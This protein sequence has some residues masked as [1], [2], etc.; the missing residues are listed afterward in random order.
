MFDRTN[1]S[2]SLN[3]FDDDEKDAVLESKQEAVKK[4][5]NLDTVTKLGTGSGGKT[6]VYKTGDYAVKLF[7]GIT[8]NCGNKNL[9][10]EMSALSRIASTRFDVGMNFFHEIGT[11]A[12]LRSVNS[13]QGTDSDSHP[14]NL[15]FFTAKSDILPWKCSRFNRVGVDYA[16]QMPLVKCLANELKTYHLQKQGSP[17]EQPEDLEKIL[18]I[19]ID[20]CDALIVMHKN[21]IIHQDIKPQNIFLD[22]DNYC[23]GDLGIAR[24]EDNRQYFL[25]GTPAYWSPEQGNGQVV[26]RRCDIYS[27]GLVLYELADTVPISAHYEERMHTDKKLPKLK[28]DVPEGLK[29]ILQNAC[30]YEPSLRYQSAEAFKNDLC[31]LKKNTGYKPKSTR[32]IYKPGNSL[33]PSFNSNMSPSRNQ[34]PRS[35]RGGAGDFHMRQRANRFFQPENLWRAGKLW[36]EESRKT[37]SRFAELKID[38]KIMPLSSHSSHAADFPIRVSESTEGATKQKPLSDILKDTENLHNMYL[39]GE[40]GIGKTTALNSIMELKYKNKEFYVSKNGKTVIPLFIEL[41]KAP[42]DYCNAYYASHSTFI[43]RYLYM[44]LASVQKQHLLSESPKEMAQIMDKQ[45]TSITDNIDMLLNMDEDH[46]QYLLLLDGLNEVSKKQ[47]STKEKDFLGTPSE[48][49][50]EEIKELLEKHKNITAIITSRADETLSDLDDSFERLYLTGVSEDVIKEYLDSCKISSE[51]VSKNSRLMET[52]RIPLFLKLYGELYNTADISTPGE[53]LYAFFSERSTKYTAR[54]RIAEIK[55]D[56]QKAGDA[57]GSNSLDEKMQWFILD[58]LLPELG[59]YMEKNDLYTVDL[60]TFHQVIDTV[61]KGENETDICGTYGRKYFKEYLKGEDPI[62]N[63][64]TYAKQLL[65]LGD[66]LDEDYASVIAKYCVYSLGILYSNNQ[67]YSFI[68]QHIRDFFAAM[69][70]ITDM[71]MALCIA[72]DGRIT[73]TFDEND[74]KKKIALRVLDTIGTNY[75]DEKVSLFIGEILGECKNT[76]LFTDGKWKIYI[77]EE[78]KRLL[79]TKTLLLYKGNFSRKASIGISVHNLLGIFEKAHGNLNGMDLSELDLSR[80]SF[81]GIPLKG[82]SLN[83]ALVNKQ[84]FFPNGHDS[85]ITCIR[86]SP[87]GEFFLTGDSCGIVKLWHL[88]TRKYVQTIIDCKYSINNI[89]YIHNGSELLVSTINGAW[90]YDALHYEIKRNFPKTQFVLSDKNAEKLIVGYN[91]ILGH[92]MNIQILEQASNKRVKLDQVREDFYAN[93]VAFSPDEKYIVLINTQKQL[94]VFEYDSGKIIAKFE[95]IDICLYDW[96]DNS[97]F[98]IS[99]ETTKDLTVIRDNIYVS[100]CFDSTGKYLAIANDCDIKIFHFPK[101]LIQYEELIEYPILGS[102]KKARDIGRILY[103]CLVWEKSILDNGPVLS[104]KFV[105]NDSFLAVAYSNQSLRLYD[106]KEMLFPKKEGGEIN[107][108]LSNVLCMDKLHKNDKYLIILCD[109]KSNIMVL[110]FDNF[111]SIDTISAFLINNSHSIFVDVIE[112]TPSGLFISAKQEGRLYYDAKLNKISS[113]YPQSS[114]ELFNYEVFSHTKKVCALGK[115]NGLIVI[116]SPFLSLNKTIKLSGK[117]ILYMEFSPDDKLLLISLTDNSPEIINMETY[118]VT[119]LNTF[120]GKAD[121]AIFSEDGR[122]IFCCNGNFIEKF[123]T[124]T[125]ERINYVKEYCE[126][127]LENF[128]NRA[129]NTFKK[130]VNQYNPSN[131]IIASPEHTYHQYNSKVTAISCSPDRLYLAVAWSRGEVEIREMETL[132]CIAILEANNRNVKTISFNA[133][134]KYMAI[135]FEKSSVK[136]Y[137]T[138]TWRCISILH[139]FPTGEIKNPARQGHS[140]LVTSILFDKNIINIREPEKIITASNDGTIKYWNPFSP[141]RVTPISPSI[142]YTEKIKKS[143]ATLWRKFYLLT[144]VILGD[145]GTTVSC[146]D[147]CECEKTL[148]FVPGLDIDGTSLQNLNPASDLTKEDLEIL[149]LYGAKTE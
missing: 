46:T 79:L 114:K 39:I 48:L 60:P 121:K 72:E 33:P 116:Y 148:Y 128:A 15:I 103:D 10:D 95:L 89:Q 134:G 29:M 74:N 52:L 47:L 104:M 13:I 54:N 37:G 93:L 92:R 129:L 17:K 135:P 50:V 51:Q 38:E 24:E 99:F 126:P 8:K 107:S 27:L 91:A 133:N 53:I 141:S 68:H 130:N 62:P 84:T 108:F 131:A 75:F 35:Y 30:E 146:K 124:K 34:A 11:V 132:S 61:L 21:S 78:E 22:H 67:S 83:G 90:I 82:S 49:L 65:A 110:C 109:A 28:T 7:C 144:G 23:L 100:L 3:D 98:E 43:Q 70:I 19:G 5:S 42:S 20:L 12:T 69:K 40:G 73:E 80:C 58:F 105:N 55:Q 45:D 44:L 139:G 142:K 143:L 136:I 118:E 112:A 2:Y 64:Q 145:E 31:Q 25:E 77:P 18:A 125:F 119:I 57:Y 76:L 113:L 123:S 147:I 26:D 41:S 66:P 102:V 137:A 85:S 87:D 127:Y 9:D 101:L 117:H 32:D 96:R 1:F 115:E 106:F 81:N 16:F 94:V 120:Q 138:H 149:K 71:K 6:I 4:F 88:K 86:I 59:W 122:F 36:Y 111:K 14:V 140:D 97:T 56:H 63:T